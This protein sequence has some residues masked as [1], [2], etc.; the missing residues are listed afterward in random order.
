[1]V[2]FEESEDD[3]CNVVGP[4]SGNKFIGNK[5]HH[6]VGRRLPVLGLTLPYSATY[7]N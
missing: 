6:N 4:C 1:M 2:F 3:C 5:I 7:K